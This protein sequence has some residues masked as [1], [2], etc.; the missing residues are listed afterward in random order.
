[1]QLVVT[2]IRDQAVGAFMQPFFSRSRGEAIRSFT[3][4]CA[5]VKSP[6]HVHPKDFVLFFLGTWDDQT[7][8]LTSVASPEALLTALDAIG[9]SDRV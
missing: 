4:A 6:F 3:D 9:M 1:M 2:A 7:A 8:G 5:D